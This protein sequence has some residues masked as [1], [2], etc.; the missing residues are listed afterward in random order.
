MISEERENEIKQA[1]G[2]LRWSVVKDIKHMALAPGLTVHMER[3]FDMDRPTGISPLVLVLT[4]AGR[5]SKRP[6]RQEF[7]ETRGRSAFFTNNSWRLSPSGIAF[8][9][10]NIAGIIKDATVTP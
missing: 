5:S 1:L 9:G 4:F 3:S 6:L 7:V 10:A 8:Y 2:Q